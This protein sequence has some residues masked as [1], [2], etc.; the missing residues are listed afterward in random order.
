MTEFSQWNV[1]KVRSTSSWLEPRN[2][3]D[4]APWDLSSSLAA[5]S[6]G[7]RGVV[8]EDCLELG[9]AIRRKEPWPLITAWK[10]A[11][12]HLFELWRKQ[13]I[14]SYCV[15]PPQFWSC[16]LQQL[17]FLTLT[18][19][20]ERG[21]FVSSVSCWNVNDLVAWSFS[22]IQEITISFLPK[23]LW[24]WDCNLDYVIHESSVGEFC[25][26]APKLLSVERNPTTDRSRGHYC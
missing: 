23:G 5:R 18:V 8:L 19:T 10:A 6:R 9:G 12:E 2:F 21:I 4:D 11:V 3:L 13:E 25:P 17:A 16:V 15:K 14:K 24:L 7:I 22:L 26:W 1:G 20:T